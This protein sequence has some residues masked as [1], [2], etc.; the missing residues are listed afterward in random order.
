MDKLKMEHYRIYMTIFWL[1][2]LIGISCFVTTIVAAFF[3]KFMIAI[4]TLL[5][6]FIFFLANIIIS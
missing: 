4:V 5:L 6:G 3:F 2:A 1:T